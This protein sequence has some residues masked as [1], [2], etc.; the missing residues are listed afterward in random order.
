MT[1]AAW[2]FPNVYPSR[3]GYA[4]VRGKGA[5]RTPFTV[6][7]RQR[8]LYSNLGERFTVSF[9]LTGSQWAFFQGW[10]EYTLN[11]GTGWATVPLQAAGVVGLTECQFPADEDISYQPLGVDDVQVTAVVITRQGT[12]M[13][14]DTFAV[15][16]GS[17]AGDPDA[18]GD[19]LEGLEKFANTDVPD[20]LGT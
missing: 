10:L 17:Y 5:Q 20:A 8:P 4:Y 14:A 13:N 11:G 9:Q 15:I 1:T 16:D 3:Q 18:Y 19:F 12:T 2:P 7:A 6:G